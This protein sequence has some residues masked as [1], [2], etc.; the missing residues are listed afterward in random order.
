MSIDLSKEQQE[1]LALLHKAPGKRPQ[2]F[3]SE[4]S[5]HLLT[6]VLELAK[7][8]WVMKERLYAHEAILAELD[9]DLQERLEQWQQ[10]PQQAAEL[11]AMRTAMINDVFRSVTA[12]EPTQKRA[13]GTDDPVPPS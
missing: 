12:K 10:T 1:T 4:G 11:D 6:M 9:I 2:F 5:D 7:H 3:G 8:M 13:A